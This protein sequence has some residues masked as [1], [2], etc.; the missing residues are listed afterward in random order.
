MQKGPENP[1]MY[2]KVDCY[3]MLAHFCSH[4]DGAD[5]ALAGSRFSIPGFCQIPGSRDFS[6]RDLPLFLIPGL[7][8]NFS[9]IFRDFC[10]C[11]VCWSNHKSPIFIIFIVTTTPTRRFQNEC[12]TYEKVIPDAPSDID[13]LNCIPDIC[14][15]WYTTIFSRPVK[16]TPKKCVNLR[17]KLSRDKTAY[18]VFGVLFGVHWRIFFGVIGACGIGMLYLLHL[19]FGMM[20]LIFSSQK[21]CRFLFSFSE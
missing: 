19:E 13:Q 17:Q 9:G 5:Q 21:M 4:L 6:G 15:F 11:F 3:P 18:L 8:R 14:H 16:G 10:F 2:Y 12:S 20:H 1:V 7:F